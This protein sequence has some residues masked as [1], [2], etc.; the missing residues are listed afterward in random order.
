MSTSSSKSYLKDKHEN[1]TNYQSINAPR[2]RPFKM[3]YDDILLELGELG[4]WQI[5]HLLALWLPSIA[6]GMFVLTYSFSGLEPSNGFRCYLKQCDIENSTYDSLN[7]NDPANFFETVDGEID[8]CRPYNL[9]SNFDPNAGDC[10]APDFN[11]S[12]PYDF[13]VE[14]CDKILYAGFEFESTFVTDNQLIC[15]KQFQVR[16]LE[17]ASTLFSMYS[18]FKRWL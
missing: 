14:N 13:K 4:P 8:Y 16:D 6:S 18:F 17:R 15:D 7:I 12:D 10:Q 1:Q 3:N 11:T 9:V 5:G 2:R